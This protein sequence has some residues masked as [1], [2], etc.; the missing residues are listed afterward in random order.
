MQA[1]SPYL[2][3]YELCDLRNFTKKELFRQQEPVTKLKLEIRE[4]CLKRILTQVKVTLVRLEACNFKR[5]DL[6]LS[7]K[8]TTLLEVKV[9]TKIFYRI[10]LLLIFKVYRAPLGGYFWRKQEIICSIHNGTETSGKWADKWP[11]IFICTLQKL[12][13]CNKEKKLIQVA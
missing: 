1:T 2:S 6:L 3:K 9:C 4:L 5:N 10:N 11:G 7:Y 12:H 13:I 8:P